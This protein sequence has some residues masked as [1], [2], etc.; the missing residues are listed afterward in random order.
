LHH[1]DAEWP[2][3]QLSFGGPDFDVHFATCGDRVFQR[4]VKVKGANA[5]QEPIKPKAP[6]L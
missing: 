1:S 6:R 2:D 4:K 3:C 5:F